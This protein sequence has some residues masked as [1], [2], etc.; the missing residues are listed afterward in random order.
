MAEGNPQQ[1]A[2]I[3]RWDF[4][5]AKFDEQKVFFGIKLWYMIYGGFM[6]DLYMDL[7]RIYGGFMED[8]WKL[9]G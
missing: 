1:E 2:S 4:T 7:W 6:E 8:L 9:Y 5:I 3:N